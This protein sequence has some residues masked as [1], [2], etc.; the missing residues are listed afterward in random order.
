M[1]VVFPPPTTSNK[2]LPIFI[3]SKPTPRLRCS[4][5]ISEIQE[6]RVCTNRSCR[7]QGSMQTLETITALAPPTVAVKS[8]G[9]LSCCGNGP[10]LVALPAGTLVGHCG[11]RARAAEVLVA[12]CGG[13]WDSDAA[14]KSLEALALRNKAE[15]ELNNNNNFSQAELF[16]SQAIELRPIGGIHITYKDRSVA[17]LALGNHSGALEDAAQALAL[18]PIYPEAYICQGDAFLAM[19]HFDSAQKSYLTALQIDPSIRRSKSFKARIANLEKLTAVP[20]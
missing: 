17:R 11:T 5:I 19:S 12:L 10:N 16:L 3:N 8:C 20:D 4:I 15:I 18:N 6:I 2:S 7:R 9:C 14:D 1:E 13:A